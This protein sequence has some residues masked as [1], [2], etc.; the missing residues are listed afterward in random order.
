MFKYNIFDIINSNDKCK[1]KF[2]LL[3][4]KYKF[5]LYYINYE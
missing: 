2:I 5:T 3:N 4:F 1:I